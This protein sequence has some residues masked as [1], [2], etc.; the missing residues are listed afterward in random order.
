MADVDPQITDPWLTLM[1]ML[2]EA[3]DQRVE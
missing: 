1:L 3:A 2:P